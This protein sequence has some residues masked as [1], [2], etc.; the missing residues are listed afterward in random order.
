MSRHVAFRA[1]V[2]LSACLLG[3]G[4]AE[5]SRTVSEE[6]G[7][8]LE[9]AQNEHDASARLALLR[10][11]KGAEHA[12]W[13]LAL[14]HALVE[15][16]D[17]DAATAAYRQALVLDPTVHEAGLGLAHLAARREDWAG[18][19]V[20]LGTH[21][22]T[23]TVA[24]P[25]LELYAQVALRSGDQRLAAV[26]VQQ[27]LVR[28][29]AQAG[30]RRL[31]LLLLVQAKRFAEAIQAAR[32]LLA[33]DPRMI[34]AWRQLAY[35]AQETGDHQGLLA[36]LE[37]AWLVTGE[38]PDRR[39]LADAQLEAGQAA[40]ALGHYRVLIAD[41]SGKRIASAAANDQLLMAAAARAASEA[42]E[43]ALAR[44]WLDAV[45]EA[46]RDRR[47][48]L[49]QARLALQAHDT[50]AAEVA[51]SA[52]LAQGESDP[53]V[54]T[55]AA[56][57]AEGAG[58]DDVAEARYRQSLAGAIAADQARLPTLR[59]AALLQRGGRGAEAR[60]LIDAHLAKHPDDGDARA[61]RAT[62]GMGD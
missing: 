5:P 53:A 14:G 51:L 27:G 34:E 54:L 57:V 55:W 31:D 59:L 62:F 7:R 44:A 49:A 58:H 50:T 9:R 30:F 11:W 17:L 35:C 23:N 41:G 36:A 22:D 33:N 29:P 1:V 28:F 2:L 61:L 3:V 38:V 20:L 18:A 60:R 37:A 39:R 48:R 24:A 40:T 32:S 45:P 16:E 21:C 25:A 42:G 4:A 43:L 12:L 56:Y 47:V 13:H 6:L 8:L 19:V 46:V 10:G 52:L 26:L 15:R